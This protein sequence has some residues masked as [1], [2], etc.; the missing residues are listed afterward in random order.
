MSMQHVKDSALFLFFLASIVATF[1]V[2]L[3]PLLVHHLRGL[4]STEVHFQ[5]KSITPLDKNFDTHSERK[6]I[7]SASLRFMFDGA[8]IGPSQAPNELGI[9]DIDSD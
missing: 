6:R 8:R 5:V 2:V 3:L 7:S 1:F 9:E 4:D